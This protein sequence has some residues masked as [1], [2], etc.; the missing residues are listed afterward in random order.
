MELESVQM[1]PPMSYGVSE[2]VGVVIISISTP[3]TSP[4]YEAAAVAEQN[5]TKSPSRKQSKLSA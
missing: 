5:N 3:F 2:Q 4:N 1:K